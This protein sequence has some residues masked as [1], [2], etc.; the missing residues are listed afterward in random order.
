MDD[1][2]IW[3]ELLGFA[4]GD[5]MRKKTWKNDLF[6]KAVTNFSAEEGSVPGAGS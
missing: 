3:I 5:L 1:F 2:I 6:L 4:F